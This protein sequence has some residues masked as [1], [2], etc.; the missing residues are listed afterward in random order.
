M[1][2]VTQGSG[3]LDWVEE[4]E[5]NI[6]LSYDRRILFIAGAVVD[7]EEDGEVGWRC[8]CVVKIEDDVLEHVAPGWGEIVTALQSY[9]ADQE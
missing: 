5:E 7:K 1:R 9:V 2:I 8:E 6:P 3:R 4:N